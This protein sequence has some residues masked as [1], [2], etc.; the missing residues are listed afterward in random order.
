[1]G[2]KVLQVQEA[3]SFLQPGDFVRMEEIGISIDFG[4]SDLD[5][6]FVPPGRLGTEIVLRPAKRGFD[7]FPGR[8][9]V[10]QAHFIFRAVSRGRG[11]QPRS[12]P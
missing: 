6:C 3:D 8:G 4:E 5:K 9:K 10:A 12:R 11:L 2:P 7:V 1:M